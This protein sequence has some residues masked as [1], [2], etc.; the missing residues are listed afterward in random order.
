ME[1]HP[2]V[3]FDPAERD[4]IQA[5]TPALNKLV[6]GAPWVT[7]Q[8]NLDA[9]TWRLA[10]AQIAAGNPINV[11]QIAALSAAVAI[12]S[13]RLGDEPVRHA[14]ALRQAAAVLDQAWGAV[15]ALMPPF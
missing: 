8:P 13:R 15:L 11:E 1:V 7:G 14:E 3:T 2:Y 6:E 9:A 10:M 12:A 5:A 4:T